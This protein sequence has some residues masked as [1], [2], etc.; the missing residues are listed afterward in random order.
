MEGKPKGAAWKQFVHGLRVDAH[1]IWL[2]V[3]DRRTPLLLRLF[4]ALVAAYALSPIDLIP[5]FVPILGYLDDAVILPVGIWIFVSLVPKPLWAELRA[6]AEAETQR[7]VSVAGAVV[8]VAVW[9]ALAALVALMV[10]SWQY[11]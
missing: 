1:A 10:A 8:M 9:I 11:Y 4:G 3:R 7:P 6:R 2:A 5:D